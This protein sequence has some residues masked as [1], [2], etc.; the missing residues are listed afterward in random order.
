MKR[1]LAIAL[2]I[3][4][5][6]GIVAFAGDTSGANWDNDLGWGNGIRDYAA[7]HG[8][9]TNCDY[10]DKYSEYEPKR[11]TPVGI[12]LDLVVYEFEGMVQQYGLD[13]IEVQQKYDLNNNEYSVFGV[14]KVNLWRAGKKLLGNE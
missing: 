9:D 10:V 7:G 1:A 8:H 13:S 2:A 4:F 6:S 14:C 5:V 3:L 12:G 11:G